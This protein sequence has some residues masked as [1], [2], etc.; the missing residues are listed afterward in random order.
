[1]PHI[2]IERILEAEESER[3]W[4]EQIERLL[5]EGAEKLEKPPVFRRGRVS[6]FSLF[7]F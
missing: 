6:L 4:K 5:L 3:Q 7:A 1:M 2:P